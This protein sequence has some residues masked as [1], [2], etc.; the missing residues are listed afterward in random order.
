ML[1]GSECHCGVELGFE[2]TRAEVVREVEVWGP[3]KSF[4]L[5]LSCGFED[6]RLTARNCKRKLDGEIQE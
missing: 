4:R 6:T 3:G 5:D 2:W 1:L